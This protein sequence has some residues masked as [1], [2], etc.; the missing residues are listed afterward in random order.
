MSK[1]IWDEIYEEFCE[2]S[3]EH[4]NMVV[5][6]K[7][8]GSTSI[9]IKLNSGLAYKVKRFAPGK[10]IMQLISEE[11]IKKKYNK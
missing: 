7:P 8:W 9:M 5:E 6:Y 11:D 10:F 1:T 2:W 3:P 4:T